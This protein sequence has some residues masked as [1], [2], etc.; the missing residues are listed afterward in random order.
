MANELQASFKP[1]VSG[2]FLVRNRNAL[3]YSSQFTGLSGYNPS[4]YS[5][6][7]IYSV[8]QGGGPFYT[9]NFPSSLSPGTYS[10]CFLQMLA[11]FPQES[12]P[13]V[14][15][16][17]YDWNGTNTAQLSDIGVSGTYQTIQL[18]RS[19]QVLNYPVYLR[20]A[21]DHVTPFISGTVSGQVSKD[22]GAAVILQSGAFTAVIGF[23]G[24][25]NL[26]ALTSGDTNANTITLQFMGAG[27]NGG[28]SDPLV[29]SY[30]LQQGSGM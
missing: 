15:V 27:P 4:L 23:P 1:A 12:D 6:Y 19:H 17:N 13:V 8:Q 16:G 24:L 26:Q 28:L 18:R 29:Q 14:D 21:A 11:T 5:G 10:V 3:I 25:Y 9:A 30:V 7:P 22:G 20:S 2:Y